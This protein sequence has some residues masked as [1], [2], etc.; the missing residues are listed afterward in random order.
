[1]I[2]AVKERATGRPR[3]VTIPKSKRQCIASKNASVCSSAITSTTYSKTVD[4]VRV[5]LRHLDLDEVARHLSKV[6]KPYIVC[7]KV[8]EDVFNKYFGDDEDLPIALRFVELCADG[9]ILIVEL[10]TPVHEMTVRKFES[11]FIRA[12]GDDDKLG[13][14]GAM[15]ARRDG[16]PNKEADATFG[17]KRNT[18]NRT[19][20][21]GNLAIEKWV[22]L[23]VE[24]ARAQNWASL[25]KAALWWYGYRGIQ[26]ILLL[27]I[28][29][30]ARDMAYHLY[31]VPNTPLRQPYNDG[32]N[33]RLLTPLQV[34]RALPEH[35]TIRGA[36]HCNRR[37][38][39]ELVTF[40][41]R[42]ILS[43]PVNEDLPTGVNEETVIN[44]REVMQQVLESR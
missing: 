43:I 1:M 28:S 16:N 38:E 34:T 25:Q 8:A 10:P 44:L 33:V 7:D 36:F 18:A 5:I 6:K 39:P 13:Q 24:V 9:R 23:A 22:T 42:R 21:P 12:W 19:P 20:P 17:P 29:E 37:G 4:E 2:K 27:Q 26:Y 41:N 14:R 35:P 30:D 31:D 32:Q 11:K 15:T 3:S 40:D